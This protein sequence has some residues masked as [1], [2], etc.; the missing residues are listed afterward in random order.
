MEGHLTCAWDA[1]VRTDYSSHVVCMSKQF[2]MLDQAYS[3]EFMIQNSEHGCG[4]IDQPVQ[5]TQHTCIVHCKNTSIPL[6]K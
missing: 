2:H 6:S 4:L 5:Q 1:H 3:F